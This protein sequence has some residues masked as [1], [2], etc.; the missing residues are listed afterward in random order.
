MKTLSDDLGANQTTLP[1]FAH[2][3]RRQPSRERIWR[4]LVVLVS[5]TA[6]AYLYTS[7]SGWWQDSN[8]RHT[9]CGTPSC[10]RNEAW[11]IKAKHG[12]VASENG[13]CSEIGV[14][15][16]KKGGNAVDAAVSTTLCIGV[17]NMFS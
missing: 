6:I 16:L 1:L 7:S 15:T 10:H 9:T 8:S 3:Q 4:V 17:V 11:L 13:L 12:A 2:V 5:W 14:Q